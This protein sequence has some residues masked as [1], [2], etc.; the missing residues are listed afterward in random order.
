MLWQ[1]REGH[2]DPAESPFLEGIY[3]ALAGQRRLWQCFGRPEILRYKTDICIV[4]AFFG[5]PKPRGLCLH[6]PAPRK[7]MFLSTT[8]DFHILFASHFFIKTPYV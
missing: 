2:M 3:N 7:I 8:G 6:T 4:K 5:L 1:A